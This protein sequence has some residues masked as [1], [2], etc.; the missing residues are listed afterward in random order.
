MLSAKCNGNRKIAPFIYRS[1]TY[2]CFSVCH[3]AD[4]NNTA[5]KHQEEQSCVFVLHYFLSYLQECAFYKL[6]IPPIPLIN[7]LCDSCLT[8]VSLNIT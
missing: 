1:V 4:N 6:L 7:L 8:A 3:W 2:K 5:G